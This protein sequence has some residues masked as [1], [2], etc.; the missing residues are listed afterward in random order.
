MCS[1]APIE[2]FKELRAFHP[3]F[4]VQQYLDELKIT[5]EEFAA[6]LG[7]SGKYLSDLLNGKCNLSRD[8]ACRLSTMTGTSVELWLNLQNAYAEKRKE[9]EQAKNASLG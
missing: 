6:R 5:Q 9:I 4:Y 1:P 3:G 2:R 7:T 8:M